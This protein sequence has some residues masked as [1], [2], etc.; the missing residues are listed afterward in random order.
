MIVRCPPSARTRLTPGWFIAC[1]TLALGLLFNLQE[2]RAQSVQG[3]LVLAT[4]Q[5]EA[6]FVGKWQRDVFAEVG[7]RLGTGVT[8]VMFPTPRLSA[9]VESGEIDGEMNRTLEYG[10]A[11]PA[12]VR[13]DESLF[14]IV[15]AVYS[16][17][18]AS[19]VEGIKSL[20][21]S[22]IVEYRRGLLG[23]ENALKPAV[24]A[25]QLSD[26]LTTEQGLKK[27]IAKRTDFYCDIDVAVLNEM[28]TAKAPEFAAVRKLFDVGA[29]T[30]LYPYLNKKAAALAP[31]L[32]VII[33]QMKAEGLIERYRRAAMREF[34]QI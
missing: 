31:K 33:R 9:A 23:C 11:H 32:A 4:D 21:P 13:V 29:S 2:S 17:G 18:A 34:G 30:P 8:V 16:A 12:L 24:P 10:A 22:A 19:Q 28:S 15:F 3:A 27:L 5:A 20:P 14:N 25:A 7:K 1:S 6:T 26:I